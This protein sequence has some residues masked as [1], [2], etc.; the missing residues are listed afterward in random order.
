MITEAENAMM[1]YVSVNGDSQVN[2]NHIVPDKLF[3]A[4]WNVKLGK[5]Y[6]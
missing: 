6:M 5:K 2:I 3:V 1:I 4:D